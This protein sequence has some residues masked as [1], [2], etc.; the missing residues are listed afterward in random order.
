LTPIVAETKQLSFPGFEASLLPT[1]RL[2][3]AIFPDA[4]AA[5]GA[6]GL[7]RRLSEQ[8]G[9]TGRPLL[10]ERFHIT[11]HHLG[12]YR[13]GVPQDIVAAA[14]AAS[15]AVAFRPFDIV[16]DRAGSFSG[17]SGSR[18]LV[19]RGG[20]GL[21]ALMAFRR[22]LGAE[23]TKTR[24]L[25]KADGPFTPHVTLLYDP[26]VVAEQV[27]DPIAWKVTEFVLVHSLL[28]QTRHIPLARWGLG[29]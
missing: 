27:I 16:F 23:L 15:K 18:P 3:L 13:G 7:A 22:A 6:A 4:Q 10:T 26:R 25:R 19:L 11:L 12:D 5:G 1:D 9:L 24:L 14:S 8:H 29:G 28:G 2:F 21:A 20:D 17:R